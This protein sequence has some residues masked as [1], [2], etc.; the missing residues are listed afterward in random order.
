M[1]WN[2]GEGI[3]LRKLNP[4]R[5]F[6]SALTLTTAFRLQIASPAPLMVGYRAMYHPE[7]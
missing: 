4:S 2:Q 6:R 1:M 5:L 7:A 3:I